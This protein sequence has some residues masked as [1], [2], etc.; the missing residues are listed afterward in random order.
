MRSVSLFLRPLT[1]IV[2]KA[3]FSWKMDQGQGSQRGH[4]AWMGMEWVL[5]TEPS[6]RAGYDLGLCSCAGMLLR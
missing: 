2:T 3:T 6:E 5:G 4:E 1:L